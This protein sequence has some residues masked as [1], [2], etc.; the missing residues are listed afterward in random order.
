MRHFFVLFFLFVS[1]AP[2]RHYTSDDWGKKLPRL[3]RLQEKRTVQFDRLV[4]SGVIEF[5]WEDEKGHHRKQGDFD[6]WRS[7]DSISIRISKV[8]ELIAWI[9]SDS[10]TSWMFDLT[11]DETILHI[12][13]KS[14]LFADSHTLLMLI[15]LAPIPEGEIVVEQDVVQTTEENGRIWKVH[16]DVNTSKPQWIQLQD[17][18]QLLGSN[19]R[20][21]L[22]VE[23]IDT[24]E[25]HWPATPSLVD[26][27]SSS[28]DTEIKLSFASLSTI[29]EDEPMDRVFN[30]ELLTNAL[31]PNQ[32][33]LS[34]KTIRSQE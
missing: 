19:L 5:K 28:Q 33:I 30:L 23:I 9:G 26:L 10:K 27:K 31:K 7:G 13:D 14:S 3:Q 25:M 20:D 18:D 21:W 4:G 16:Y 24:H 29:V 11:S 1:C 8:G 17:G 6:F 22:R 34:E 32:T 15:G 2:T 12:D